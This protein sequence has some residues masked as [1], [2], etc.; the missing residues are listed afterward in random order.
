[1]PADVSPPITKTKITTQWGSSVSSDLA[2]LWTALT[3]L[4]VSAGISVEQALDAVAAALIAGNNI[5]I[6]VDDA[7]NTITF[8]VEPLNKADVGLT[9]VDNTP[10][11][12]KPIST[13]TQTALDTKAAIA[14]T[15]STTA[16]LSGGGNLGAN[17]TLDIAAFTTSVKGAVPPP[18][19]TTGKVLRDSGSW[20]LLT[21]SDVGLGNVNNTADASKPVSTAQ[22]TALNLKADRAGLDA[23]GVR[24]VTWS[25]AANNASGGAYLG[26]VPFPVDPLYDRMY[27]ITWQAT[28]SGQASNG[29][30]EPRLYTGSTAYWIGGTTSYFTN[31]PLTTTWSLLWGIGKNQV[32]TFDYWLQLSG[33]NT[34]INLGVTLMGH[35]MAA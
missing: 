5:D 26:S 24:H 22:Q 10:D 35:V 20:T 34:N 2:E 19:T 21:S 28:M 18:T 29:T 25:G 6:T 30:A 31:L 27:Q 11:A 32:L 17:R 33:G 1:M 23:R 15:I 13:A 9:N 16:P 3:E 7:A 14:T 4:Q 12:T 8:N